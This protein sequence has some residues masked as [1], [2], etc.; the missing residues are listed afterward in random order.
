MKKR[1]TPRNNRGKSG[2]Q[3]YSPKYRLNLHWGHG[4]DTRPG[5]GNFVDT[6]IGLTKK[7]SDLKKEG[8]VSESTL[9][10]IDP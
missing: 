8:K 4:G 2:V 3:A 1:T 5:A 7:G 9:R 6:Y 10:R